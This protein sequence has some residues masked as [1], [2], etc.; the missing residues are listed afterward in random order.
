MT[1]MEARITDLL[2]HVYQ[3]VGQQTQINFCKWKNQKKI[4]S[5]RTTRAYVLQ[6]K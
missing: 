1:A 2:E 6:R 5:N 4:C 3:F